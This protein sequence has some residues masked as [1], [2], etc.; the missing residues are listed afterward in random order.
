LL[1]EIRAIRKGVGVIVLHDFRVPDHPE[2]GF[3]RY[4]DELIS[5]NIW[6][7]DECGIIRQECIYKAGQPFEYEYVKDA[8]TSWS[9][10]HK[11]YYNDRCEGA[12]YPRGVLFAFPGN[13]PV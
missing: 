6:P 9:S 10:Q 13:D 8:L 2:L 7:P 1:D 11:I 5:N 12:M 4:G 3:D